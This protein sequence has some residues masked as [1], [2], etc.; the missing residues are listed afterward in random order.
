MKDDSLRH[1]QDLGPESHVPASYLT[2]LNTYMMAYR[3]A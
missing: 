2:S 1:M 3:R